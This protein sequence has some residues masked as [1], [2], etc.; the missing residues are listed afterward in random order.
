MTDDPA[1]A[2]A[3]DDGQA[4]ERFMGRWSRAAGE[5]FLD[6]VAPPRR[7]GWLDVGCGTGAFTDLVIRK[8]APASVVGVDPACAQIEYCR[9]QPMAEHV[10][11]RVA[12]A[13]AMP[14]ARGSFDVIA[15]ALVLNFVPDIRLALREMRRVGRS[16][17]LVAGY[18]WDFAAARAPNSCIALGLH[19][20]GIAAPSPPGTAVSTLDSLTAAFERAGFD[21][22]GSTSF[23]IDITFATFDDFWHA[24]TPSFSPLTRIVVGLTHADRMKLMDFVRA[25]V[26][27]AADGTTSWSARANAIRG[28]VP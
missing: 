10:D 18:V 25:H 24:H 3:F 19:A 2:I 27:M 28:R 16:G 9:R 12:H 7:A 13:Q 14:F 26:V 6:W 17:G 8:C 20:I 5:I 15:S 22:V 11:F 4:Y 1:T 21:D 23:D